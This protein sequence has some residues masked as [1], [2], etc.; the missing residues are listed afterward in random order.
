MTYPEQDSLPMP[1]W[2][3]LLLLVVLLTIMIL[4]SNK[5][6]GTD[7]ITA[8]SYYT[9]KDGERVTQHT[10]VEPPIRVSGPAQGGWSR[11]IIRGPDGTIDV[12]WSGVPYYGR[13]ITV[14]R[15]P[16]LYVPVLRYLE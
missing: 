1:W 4:V 5:V 12:Y 13:R 8:P 16:R 14:Y 15:V 3:R 11:S 6:Y 7:W 9:H 2:M 10:P